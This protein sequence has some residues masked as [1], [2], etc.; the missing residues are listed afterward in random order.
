M[1][2]RVTEEAPFLDWIAEWTR[3]ATYTGNELASRLVEV[4]GVRPS[5]CRR[6]SHS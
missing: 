1:V 3:I 4:I 2:D 6:R 5:Q